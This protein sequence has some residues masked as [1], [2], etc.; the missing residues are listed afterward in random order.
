MGHTRRG[1]GKKIN[2]LAVQLHAMGVP[3]VIPGPAEILGV[4]P[5]P[6]AETVQR[7]GHVFVVLGQMRVHHH[8]LVTRKKGGITHQLPADGEGRTGRDGDPNHGLG[9][10]IVKLIYD[11]NTVA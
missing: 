11:A 6:A 5:G 10:C 1:S 9:T 2:L 8:A 7:I 4:L 3:D